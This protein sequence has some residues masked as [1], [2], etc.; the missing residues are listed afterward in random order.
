MPHPEKIPLKVVEPVED[1]VRA[2]KVVR[3]R[4][5]G[6]S[7]HHGVRADDHQRALRVAGL[8][9]H[10]ERARRRALGLEVRELLDRAESF[11]AKAACEWTESVEIA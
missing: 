10:A 1:Q 9:Q 5:P 6:S 7:T 11:S 2:R 4:A 8:V 3:S